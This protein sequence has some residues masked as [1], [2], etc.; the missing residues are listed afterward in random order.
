MPAEVQERREKGPTQRERLRDVLRL[1][2]QCESWLTLEELARKTSFPP[3]SISA[4]LRHLRK[5]AYGGWI[6][7]KRPRIWEP[8]L[9]DGAR[10]WEYRLGYASAEGGEVGEV[11]E[12]EEAKEVVERR[13]AVSL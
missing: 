13:D 6:V 1:A 5:A 8:G 3:A 2:A 11:N 12:A 4:Q 7:E 9:G 10:V